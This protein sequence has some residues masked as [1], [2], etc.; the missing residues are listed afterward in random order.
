[1]YNSTISHTDPNREQHQ[2]TASA[3]PQPAPRAQKLH[4]IN[5]SPY[6]TTSATLGCRMPPT[7]RAAD[8]TLPRL[9]TCSIPGHADGCKAA[10]MHCSCGRWPNCVAECA[11]GRNKPRQLPRQG[12]PHARLHS[13]HQLKLPSNQQHHTHQ[14]PPQPSVQPGTLTYPSCIADA[15]T[16]AVHNPTATPIPS[17]YN[18]CTVLTTP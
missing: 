5:N 17:R 13:L 15:A 6:F 11:T 3:V 9:A 8:V 14:A 18:P 7:P 10:G 16:V 2:H 4:Y 12:R 1:M